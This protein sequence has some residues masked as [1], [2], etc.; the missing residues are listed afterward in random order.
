MTIHQVLFSSGGLVEL[1]VSSNISRYA[2]FRAV[3]R[4]ASHFDNKIITVP[5]SRADV[6]N[7][8]DLNVVEKRI[9]MK[10]MQ[11][12]MNSS[13]NTEL[14]EHFNEKTFKEF[15]QSQKLTGKL[16][17]FV[18]YSIAMADEQTK[19]CDGIENVKKFLKSLGRYGN[20]SFLFPMYGSGEM[21]QCFCR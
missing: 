18:L 11:T 12:C 8:K 13:E 1:L 17:H 3:D 21:P 10:F 9:L 15:L 6:F 2:E 7:N 4:I 14:V 5:C 20:T 19:C 16:L